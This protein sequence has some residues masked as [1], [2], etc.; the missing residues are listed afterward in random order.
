MKI[1]II[2]TGISGLGAAWLLKPMH[3]ITVYEENDYIGGHSR[4]IKIPGKDMPVYVDTGFIV[5]NHKNYPHL[6]S[7]FKELH[8]PTV[9]SDMSFAASVGNSW[10]EYGSKGMFA[11]KKN[12]LRPAFW[13]MIF[14]IMR[15]NKNAL[16]YLENHRESTLRELLDGM[17]LGEWFRRYYLQAMGAAIWSCSTETILDFPARTFLNFFENH[18]LLTVNAHPQWYTV[19]GG[20][21][22]YVQRLI[23]SFKDNILLNCGATNVTRAGDK[24][25]VK[26]RTGRSTTF[27]HVIFACHANQALRLI[28]APTK[29]QSSVLG[30]FHYQKNRVVVHS[31][32][33]FMP[34]HKGCW[35]SW[36]YHS[37]APIDRKPVVSLSYWMNQLQPLDTKENIFVTLNPGREPDSS[38]VHDEYIFEH[39][40]FTQ[41][42]LKAQEKIETIQGQDNM[43]HCGAY[44][45]YGFHEDGL[46]SA[47]AVSVK[48][49][50]KVPWM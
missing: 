41:E 4:T 27:D 6:T 35:A 18:G 16:R 42:T 33:S 30:A 49:G 39:P 40:V 46:I 21:R 17:K 19:R 50:A 29:E 26:D 3:D 32:E 7:L 45:R 34:R 20:S 14:D 44:Q 23:L 31:D 8:V 25:E 36:V 12:I 5:F 13:G 10:L 47:I 37:N 15:F 43:W 24:V 48:L 2:G 28:S 1:A 11:Q 38:L 9:K 22:E